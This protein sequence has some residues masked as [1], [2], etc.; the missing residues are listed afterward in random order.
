MTEVFSH[1]F[2]NASTPFD[3]WEFYQNWKTN[4]NLIFK[5]LPSESE[6]FFFPYFFLFPKQKV[7]GYERRR[8]LQ[9]QCVNPIVTREFELFPS[10]DPQ[11]TMILCLSIDVL[12]IDGGGMLRWHSLLSH[13]NLTDGW[14]KKFLHCSN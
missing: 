11:G 6:F 5:L 13:Q 2:N 1:V 14:P 9:L 3:K 8:L 4:G 7:R 12:T 10:F